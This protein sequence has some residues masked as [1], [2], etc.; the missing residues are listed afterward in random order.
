MFDVIASFLANNVKIRT[1]NM[2][3]KSGAMKIGKVKYTRLRDD[4]FF[5]FVWVALRSGMEDAVG[6]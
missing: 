3:D 6:F 1:S 5:R 4:T 2:P